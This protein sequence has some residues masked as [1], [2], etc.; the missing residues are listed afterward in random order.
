[1]G[2]ITG[3]IHVALILM[4]SVVALVALGFGIYVYYTMSGQE[5]GE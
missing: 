5:E 2:T 4:G 3:V 1:M